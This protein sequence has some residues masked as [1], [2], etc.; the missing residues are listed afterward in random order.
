MNILV[1]GSG[2]REH[3]LAWA[4]S[5]SPLCDTLYV[6]PGNGGTA[7]FACNVEDLAITNGSGVCQLAHN[8]AVGIVE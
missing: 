5:K 3:A 4:L 8:H 7:R 6:A 2:G 1:L